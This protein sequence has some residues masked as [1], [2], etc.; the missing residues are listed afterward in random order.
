MWIGTR[1][2]GLWRFRSGVT[3]RIRG[4]PSLDGDH[5]GA[6]VI[7]AD[8]TL[9]IGTGCSGF[10]RRKNEKLEFFASRQGLPADTVRQILDDGA[11]TLWIGGSRGIAR[12]WGLGARRTGGRSDGQDLSADLG[13]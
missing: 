3:E 10:T 4:G 9:W 1:G 2:G 7:D 11:G 12:L 13:S 8:D 6:L 5:V